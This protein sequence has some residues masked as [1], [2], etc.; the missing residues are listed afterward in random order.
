[1]A[2]GSGKLV[3]TCFVLLTSSHNK[4][5]RCVHCNQVFKSSWKK[6][7]LF[8]QKKYVLF[9]VKYSL[10]NQLI[11]CEDVRTFASRKKI[12]I[13]SLTTRIVALLIMFYVYKNQTAFKI[14]IL[15]LSRI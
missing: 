13:V 10:L 3:A 2:R 12:D 14:L 8:Y 5:K 1:M 11:V 9:S 15:Y 4:S 7:E 6:L